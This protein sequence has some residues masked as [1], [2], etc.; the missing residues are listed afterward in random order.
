M[1]PVTRFTA[2]FMACAL[3]AIPTRAPSQQREAPPDSTVLRPYSERIAGTLVSLEMLP[4]N[5]G[6]VQLAGAES[7]RT[8]EVAPFWMSKT[9]VPW[10]AYDVFAFG[11]D[12]GDS[13]TGGADAVT[14]P[15]RPYVLPGEHFG[16]RGHPAIGITHHAALT[17]AAWLKAKTGRR[18][19]LPTAAE[20]EHACRLGRSEISQAWHAGNAGER[21][22]PVATLAPNALGLQDL[23]G[24]VAEWVTL[25]D[26]K[27][28]AK[29][30]SFL[31][32]AGG[33]NCATSTTQTPAWNATDPQ[34]PKS[35]WWLTDAPFVGFRLVR[36]P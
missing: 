32:D 36:E 34:L 13:A 2:I 25:E 19:R 8:V 11:L 18:Y 14:R 23:L 4:V 9:E 20:W 26:G 35:R 24:N 12:R 22:H 5:G 6:R 16:H 31:D 21:T 33:V 15:T 10:D 30:G 1:M 7:A 27:P 28:L 17:F 3:P 29:G